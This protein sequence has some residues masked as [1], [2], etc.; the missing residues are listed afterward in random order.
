MPPYTRHSPGQGHTR[1][2]SC[3]CVLP[4]AFSCRGVKGCCKPWKRA[5]KAT[6][7]SA[8]RY[9]DGP[10]PKGAGSPTPKND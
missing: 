4:W 2:E 9:C 3:V 1:R 10:H 6:T 7:R 5:L 8:A